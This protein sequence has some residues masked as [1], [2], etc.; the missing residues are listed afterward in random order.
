MGYKEGKKRYLGGNVP[1]EQL[2]GGVHLFL[3]LKL[4]S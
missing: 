1:N 4:F 2:K 3:Y